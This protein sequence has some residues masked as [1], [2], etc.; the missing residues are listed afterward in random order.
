MERS[1][2]SNESKIKNGFNESEEG[3]EDKR[4]QRFSLEKFMRWQL[5]PMEVLMADNRQFRKS[6]AHPPQLPHMCPDVLN[7]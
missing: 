3:M 6:D 5:P 1:M 7:W 2:N 4:A